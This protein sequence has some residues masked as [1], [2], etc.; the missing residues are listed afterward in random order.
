VAVTRRSVPRRTPSAVAAAQQ[1][2]KHLVYVHGICQHLRGYSNPWWEALKPYVPDIP[3]GNRHEVLWSDII[4]PTAIPGAARMDD[5]A[6]MLT[7]PADDSAHAEVTADLRDVLADRALH[8]L[9]EASLPLATTGAPIVGAAVPAP[10][11][12]MQIL[13]PLAVVSIPQVECVADFT[14]YLLETDI[15]EQV[16]GRFLNDVRPLLQ[17]G[18]WVEVISHSWGT[19]VAYEALRRLDGDDSLSGVVATLFTVGSALSIPPVKRRLLPE[20]LDGKRPGKVRRWVNLHARFDI[21][22]GHLRDNPFAV[23]YEYLNLLPVGC[24]TLVPNP[25]C[26]HGSYFNKDNLPVNKDIFGSFIES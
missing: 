8:L 12:S 21:V 14:R 9:L 10:T 13:G 5:L 20:A 3:D 25:W 17:K 2:A 1:A 22:G 15:R 23:D 6:R 18:A 4:Q 19:V 7:A 16:I 26:A 24:S 11:L